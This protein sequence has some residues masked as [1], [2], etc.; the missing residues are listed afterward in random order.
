MELSKIRSTN[1]LWM[2]ISAVHSPTAVLGLLSVAK[3]DLSQLVDPKN[4]LNIY[5]NLKFVIVIINIAYY[6]FS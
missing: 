6:Y 2:K 3:W 5:P 1:A 4:L